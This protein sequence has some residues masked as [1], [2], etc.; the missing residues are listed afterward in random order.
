[1]KRIVIAFLLIVSSL[2][3]SAQNVE[4]NTQ[5]DYK[6]GLNAGFGSSLYG[7]VTNTFVKGIYVRKA[8]AIPVLHLE[9]QR[10][11]QEDIYMGINASYQYFYFDLLPIDTAHSGVV[12]KINKLNLGLSA[13]YL[14]LNHQKFDMYFGGQIG[15]SF[16][17]GQISFNQLIDYTNEVFPA[18]L[19]NIITKRLISS[20]KNFFYTAYSFQ[21]HLGF[22]K[23][24]TENLGIRGELALGSPYMAM[25][26]LNYRF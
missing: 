17:T 10:E 4:N 7:L 23:Y 18:F 22:D 3:L 14:F 9:Y 6:N 21:T 20:S 16:W 13:D 19:S 12:T 25:I 1:M 11:V 8:N 15:I 24:F 5:I 26:G 2:A